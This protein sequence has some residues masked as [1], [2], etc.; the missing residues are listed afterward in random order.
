MEYLVRLEGPAA[1]GA[2]VDRIRALPDGVVAAV[3][4]RSLKGLQKRA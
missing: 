3:E 4:L 2:V 1:Q